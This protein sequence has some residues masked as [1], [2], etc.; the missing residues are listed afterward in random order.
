MNKKTQKLVDQLNSANAKE[1][2]QAVLA[3]GKLG[4][5]ELIPHLDKVANI[6]D[7]PKVKGLAQKAVKTLRVLQEREQHAEQAAAQKAK[8]AKPKQSKPKEKRSFFGRRKKEATAA[9]VAAMDD[10][11]EAGDENIE[12]P[13]LMKDKM[14]ADREFGQSYDDDGFDYIESKK[15]EAARKSERARK[16]AEAEE[17]AR[18]AAIS[19]EQ[20]RRRPFR[21]FLLLITFIVVVLGIFALWYVVFVTPP[22][23][24][25]RAVVE[26]LQGVTAQ[27]ETTLINYNTILSNDPIDCTLVSDVTLPEVPRWVELTQDADASSFWVRVSDNLSRVA[28][29]DVADLDPIMAAVLTVNQNLT[30]VKNNLD[31]ICNE[32]T[33]VTQSIWTDYA[34]TIEVL[35]NSYNLART[36]AI[37]LQTQAA[38]LPPADRADA[39]Q[40]LQQWLE[41]Q[42]FITD[43]YDQQ[44][45][46]TQINCDLLIGALPPAPPSWVDNPAEVPTEAIAGLEV[47]T[48]AL[49]TINGNLNSLKI[50]MDNAC[51]GVTGS[52]LRDDWQFAG[53]AIEQNNQAIELISTA[54][55]L[56]EN[57]LPD[58]NAD[59]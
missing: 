15:K 56:L 38:L 7:H 53:N 17:A 19:D 43:A 52:I 6:D 28:E 5:T 35:G 36:S 22:P 26:D 37:D 50:Y 25:R 51:R 31:T 44:F 3:L 39:L 40:D 13:E 9:P 20:K 23:E 42:T 2:Y 33:E 8:K 47:Y 57:E 46:S 55:L 10:D 1:R 45:S 41:V 4:D 59:E 30:D 21:L 34:T 32:R 24:D 18:L 48:D 16:R 14:M 54:K 58:N 49:L 29:S 27:Q 11:H 12:W